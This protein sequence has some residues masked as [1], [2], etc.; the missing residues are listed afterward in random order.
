[1]PAD[2]PAPAGGRARPRAL[3]TLPDVA[4]PL[5]GGK[6][7][8]CAGVLRGLAE[9]AD[10]DLAVLHS[11]APEDVA[12]VPPDV[13]VR[14]WT[15][16]APDPLPRSRAAL[17]AARHA[18]PVHVAAQRWD[19]VR[20]HL[21]AWTAGQQYDLVWF[22]GLDHAV[23]LEGDLA[24]P[25]R[26]VDCDDVETEKWRAY[27]RGPATGVDR[28][29]RLQR[30]VELPLWGRVQRQ[31]L[32]WADAVVVC[33][34][35]D[36]ARLGGPSTVVV[37]NT[38]PDPGPPAP[39]TP[40][41]EPVVVVVANYA[42]P[43]NVDAARAAALGV[44]PALRALAP[45]ARLRL[46]GRDADRLEDLRGLPGLDLVGPV[47]SVD[48]ELAGATAVVVPMRF[49]GGTRLK[50]LEA[51]ARGVP[52]V[53]T[54]LGCEGVGARD[55]EHLLVREDAASTA[56]A[57]LD[58]HRDPARADALARAARALYERSFTPAASTGAVTRLVRDV[59]A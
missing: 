38:Y 23:A 13:A 6:R 58:L 42:T 7:L 48:A 44:L 11:R 20:E 24:A 17:Q 32:G 54:A 2:A 25:V 15:R 46:V 43:Q 50:V 30:R 40:P 52:V 1:M 53:S 26:V 36:A 14:R 47:P 39:R 4:W 59:L 8:R 21:A 16:T 56:A 35:V 3:V 34:D 33:S 57:V 19:E 49:G 28:T 9:V 31:V 29:E 37:P 41:A 12:P 51:F 55:G 5:D 18:L 22:G 27:L 45:T 10:V